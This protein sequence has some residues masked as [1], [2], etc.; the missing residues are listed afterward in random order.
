MNKN[1]IYIGDVEPHSKEEYEKEIRKG[2]FPREITGSEIVELAEALKLGAESRLWQIETQGRS[3]WDRETETLNKLNCSR[4][5]TGIGNKGLQE[6]TFKVSPPRYGENLLKNRENQDAIMRQILDKETR[7]AIS[8]R[9]LLE[10]VNEE[11]SY[12]ESCVSDSKQLG[13]IRNAQ[14][15][16][17]HLVK[18]KLP[19]KDVVTVIRDRISML[20]KTRSDL[21]G[22]EDVSFTLSR[23]DICS[24]VR[25]PEFIRQVKKFHEMKITGSELNKRIDGELKYFRSV[26]DTPEKKERLESIQRAC[27]NT[28]EKSV[29][30]IVEEKILDLETARLDLKGL[31]KGTFTVN[32]RDNIHSI[33]QSLDFERQVR[34]EK[35]RLMSRGR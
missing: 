35:S 10:R 18:Q 26:I 34:M 12:L 32:S 14:K 13:N 30:T 2:G 9:D 31:E 21:N 7:H 33:V 23:N 6:A 28:R 5:I 4:I 20:D 15:E 29:V 27:V 1:E 19:E 22:L 17:S 11:I 8:G 16:Y 25:N 24:I 3:Q